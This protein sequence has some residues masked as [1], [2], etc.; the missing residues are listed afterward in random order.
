MVSDNSFIEQ[1]IPLV[2][3]AIEADQA[4]EYEDAIKLYSDALERL[5][6][7]LKYEKNPT[8]KQLLMERVEGYMKRAEEIRKIV[9]D[10]KEGN[11]KKDT[12]KD[13]NKN[14][15]ED[16]SSNLL[17]DETKKLRG[18]LAGAVVMERPN[19]KW[20]DVAGLENAK[21]SLKET[22]IL[23]VKFPQL[24]V[25]ERKPFKGILLFGPP[26]TGKSFLAKAVATEADSTFFSVSSA[27]LMSKWQGESEK[28]V[29][30]LFEM[31][32]ESVEGDG[33]AIIFI[34]EVDSLCGSRSEG[35][36]DSSR[37]VKTEFLVQMDGVGKGGGVLV[38]GAS[39]VPW[40]LDSAI[41][42]RFE[43]RVYIS[44]PEQPARTYMF[45]LH[46]GIGSDD[47]T[48]H[49]LTEADFETLG[50]LSEGASGSDIQVIVKEAL[51]E[52]I[53][54]CQQAKQFLINFETG[55]YLPCE[56]YPACYLCPP[57]LSFDPPDKSY[58]CQSVEEGGCGA[59][60]MSLWDIDPPEKLDAP[61]VTFKD[62]QTVMSHAFSTV[63]VE[64]LGRYQE[65]TAMFGQEGG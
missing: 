48:S 12:T 40:D 63:S 16:S 60:R 14:P 39:N 7:G 6:L 13:N 56:T 59:V 33:R 15:Q 9:D 31:A 34:D 50:K 38:L 35:E 23:P 28:L 37:R 51:M 54:R 21:E 53:R 3:K 45:Q 26:G 32:R 27:D 55:K 10:K 30:N 58:T 41:R 64:E 17:D 29:R 49:N 62:F 46:M 52:P 43:K 22:V 47:V 1:G 57:Q 24:F 5:T 19:V 44:L 2:Q 61:P 25:G 42:R 8:R 20:D 65:W 4:N 18:A 11:T 36:A